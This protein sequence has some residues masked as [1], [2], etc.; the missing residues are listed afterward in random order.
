MKTFLKVLAGIII[1]AVLAIGGFAFYMTRGLEAG[2]ELPVGG[3]NA[4][5][6]DAGEYTGKYDGGRWSNE[7]RLTVEAG[8]ITQIDVIKSVL[9][10][11][12]ELTK[13]LF[14]N[15]IKK[16]DT[17]VDAISG[18]TVTCRAYLKSIENAL[19]NK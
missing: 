8:R 10:E 13:E 16:Q 2:A 9:F 19:S 7:V 12:P 15:V 14:D 6:M 1:L 11:R 3:I 18:A 17:G 5:N 4:S